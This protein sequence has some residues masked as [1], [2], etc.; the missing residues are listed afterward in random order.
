MMKF[1][2][3]HPSGVLYFQTTS[4]KSFV[5]ELAKETGMKTA[6]RTTLDLML[7]YITE[8]YTHYY[9]LP[10]DQEKG[11][12][13]VLQVLEKEALRYKKEKNEVPVLVVDGID[14]LAKHNEKLCYLL[15]T[16]AKTLANKNHI[17]MILVS[18]E[19]AIVPMNIM[20]KTLHK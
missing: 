10:E 15:I 8:R 4:E 19:G 20:S 16:I 18:S 11:L 6:P 7:G 3:E 1:C 2:H 14:I 12:V 5:E 9:I 17:K 13:N